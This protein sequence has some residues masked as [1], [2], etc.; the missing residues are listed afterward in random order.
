VTLDSEPGRGSLFTVALPL[1]AAAA[2]RQ[3]S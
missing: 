2:L 3:A 1:P